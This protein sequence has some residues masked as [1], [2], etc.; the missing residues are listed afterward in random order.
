MDNQALNTICQQLQAVK[1]RITQAEQ[2]YGRIPGSVK[3]LAVS[4]YQALDQVLT[5]INCQQHDFGESYLNEAL[6]K[7][8]HCPHDEIR[9]HYIGPIQSN[10]TKRIAQHFSWVHSVDRLVIAKR[11]NDQRPPTLAPLNIC[12]QINIS[13]EDSKSG[14]PLSMLPELAHAITHLPHIKLRG[15]MAIPAKSTDFDTQREN[16]H[17]ISQAK[18]SL[19]ASGIPLDTLSMGMSMDLEAAIAEGATMVR[20]GTAI[21]GPRPITT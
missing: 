13:N 10:K 1:Q 2:Q 12:L 6:S 20:V 17:Q 19:I 4:K 21:F 7:I 16:F 11:L 5:A 3:L 15:L 18:A 14:C 8:T 9:W